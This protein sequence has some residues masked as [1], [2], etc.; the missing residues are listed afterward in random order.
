[1]CGLAA[2]QEASAERRLPQSRQLERVGGF[3]H[4]HVW[5]GDATIADA[6][7]GRLMQCCTHRTWCRWRSALAGQAIFFDRG[8]ATCTGEQGQSGLKIAAL[9]SL[10]KELRGPHGR[11]LFCHRADDEWVQ[12]GAVFTRHL[13]S[14]L[15]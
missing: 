9:R 1:M 3:F 13:L 5:G 8:L 10:F 15:L 4:G 2:S 14:T 12:G 11:Q 6:M 7:F